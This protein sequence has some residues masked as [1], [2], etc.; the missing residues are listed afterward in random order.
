MGRRPSPR[1]QEASLDLEHE[2]HRLR[3]GTHPAAPSSPEGELEEMPASP[4]EQGC[5]RFELP[6]DLWELNRH[7]IHS[8]K[9]FERRD[10]QT[11]GERGEGGEGNAGVVS[12]PQEA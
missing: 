6:R 9:A 10:A 2:Q 3:V 7:E 8:G 12:L 4:C 11:E 5:S 1:G